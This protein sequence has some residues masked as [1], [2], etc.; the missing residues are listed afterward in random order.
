KAA[1]H[2]ALAAAYRALSRY[3]ESVFHGRAALDLCT[4]SFKPDD[5]ETLIATYELGQGLRDQGKL[6]EAD[7]LLTTA[8]QRARNKYGTGDAVTRKLIGALGLV[9]VEQGRLKDAHQLLQEQLDASRSQA[10]GKNQ[11]PISTMN[12][13]ALVL[14]YEGDLA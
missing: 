7:P 14:R 3:D 11:E 9:R 1:I 8:L 13:L 2:V 5:R 12:N 4:V 10:N 6:N